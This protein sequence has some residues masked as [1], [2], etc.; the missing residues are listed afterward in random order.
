MSTDNGQ[1]T[2]TA[3]YHSLR[4]FKTGQPLRPMPSRLP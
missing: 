3:E 2:V 4:P 1:G